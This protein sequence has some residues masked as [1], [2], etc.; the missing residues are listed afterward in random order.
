MTDEISFHRATNRVDRVRNHPDRL[1]TVT[2]SSLGSGTTL[3]QSNGTAATTPI[4]SGNFTFS[5]V[6]NG[7]YTVTPTKAGYSFSPTSRSVTVNGANVTGVSFTATALQTTWTVSGTVSPSSLGSGTTLALSNGTSSTADS[8]GNF[9]FSGVANGTYTVTPTKAGYSFSPTSRSVTMNGA[10]VAGLAFTATQNQITSSITPDVGVWSD[11][12][13][14][15]ATITSP[16]FSTQSANEL[17]LAFIS[18]DYISGTNTTV[19]SISGAGLT[20][21]LVVRTNTQSGTSE[22]WRAFAIAAKSSVSVS[23]TLSQPVAAS[24]TVMSFTGVDTTGSNGSGAIGATSSNNAS[25]GAPTAKLVTTRNKSWVF[26]V[27]NDYDNA[28]ARTPGS[29]QTVVHQ[30][31][32]TVGDTYWVQSQVSP[33]AASGTTVTINDTAPTSDRFNLSLVEILPSLS[34]PGQ[35]QS[36]MVLTSLTPDN[37]T[38]GSAPGI[39]GGASTLA[40]SNT[41][42]GLPGDSCSP[43]G[44]ATLTGSG[45]TTQAPTSASSFPVPTQL[46]GVQ[47]MVNGMP[48]PLLMVSGSQVN[49]QCPVLSSGSQ[50]TITLRAEDAF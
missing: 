28:I 20:W 48:A 41:A 7:T 39:A 10:N 27:A 50:L 46:A 32:A 42:S 13:T 1:R 23:A 9:T 38:L 19:K 36:N 14:A 21:V 43:G 17:L 2:P 26:G 30:Y 24:M 49:F 12:S 40:M 25:S 16:T 5:G 6:A 22:I 4:A 47:V 34:S 37:Q 44:L 11:Q 3:A 15:S 29:G 35:S 31:L 18:S 33:T 8:S 45:F